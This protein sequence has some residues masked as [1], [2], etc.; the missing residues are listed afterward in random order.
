M[1]AESYLRGAEAVEN[2]GE[3]FA[4]CICRDVIR[5]HAQRSFMAVFGAEKGDLHILGSHFGSRKETAEWSQ[6]AL[7]F[8]A[9]MTTTGD[10]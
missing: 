7:C 5:G 2:A 3:S 10:L 8:A 6:T 9:A 4:C 1:K